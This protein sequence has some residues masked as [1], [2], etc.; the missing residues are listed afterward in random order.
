MSELN[1]RPTEPLDASLPLTQ[2]TLDAVTAALVNDALAELQ[3]QL[4][5]DPDFT[6][7]ER[8]DVMAIAQRLGTAKVRSA[9]MRAYL[10]LA[11]GGESTS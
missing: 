7:Q 2:A 5:L 9:L 4:E 1:R 11:G 10:A 6:P 3:A 8:Q